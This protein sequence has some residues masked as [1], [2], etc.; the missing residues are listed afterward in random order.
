MKP[1]FL[2]EFIVSLLMV[3]VL[4]VAVV[5]IIEFIHLYFTF[6]LQQQV[7]TTIIAKLIRFIIAIT[8]TFD[9]PTS[10]LLLH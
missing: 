3:M 6:K 10:T 9:T 5:L 1:L 7:T 4:V 8:V 2:I